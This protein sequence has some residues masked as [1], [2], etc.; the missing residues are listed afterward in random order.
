VGGGWWWWWERGSEGE[1]LRVP[2]DRVCA[3]ERALKG[4]P[5]HIAPG[6]AKPIEEPRVPLACLRKRK[7][8]CDL[9]LVATEGAQS[10]CRCV[11]CEPTWGIRHNVRR[12]RA[13]RGGPERRS[14]C[15][16]AS[17]RIQAYCC[18]SHP[19]HMRRICAREGRHRRVGFART[20][21]GVPPASSDKL[22]ARS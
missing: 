17:A 8:T 22:R 18:S 1:S 3:S 7:I 9:T 4:L 21:H 12:P 13:V 2:S 11:W 10:R 15:S 20:V 16:T 14:R 19:P 6:P 5:R